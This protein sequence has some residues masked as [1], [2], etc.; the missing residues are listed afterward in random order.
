MGLGG[1]GERVFAL[2]AFD[3]QPALSVKG[4]MALCKEDAYI[5]S[6]KVAPQVISPVLT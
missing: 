1:Q 3:A 2:V 4:V 5:V 6:I